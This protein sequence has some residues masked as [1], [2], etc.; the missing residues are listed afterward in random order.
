[1]PGFNSKKEKIVSV[2]EGDVV[3]DM[4]ANLLESGEHTVNKANPELT[5]INPGI[6]IFPGRLRTFKCEKSYMYDSVNEEYVMTTSVSI[7]SNGK[8]SYKK[9]RATVENFVILFSEAELEDE[10]GIA[11]SVLKEKKRIQGHNNCHVVP[12]EKG[13]QVGEELAPDGN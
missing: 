9:E 4:V 1:L 12:K 8:K 13:L 10:A 5:L 11:A 6:A 7:D 2:W 3:F